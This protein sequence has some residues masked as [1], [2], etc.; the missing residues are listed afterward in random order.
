MTENQIS[1]APRP[2]LGQ[3]VPQRKKP[4]VLFRIVQWAVVAF[5]ALAAIIMAS[6]IG[7]LSVPGAPVALFWVALAVVIGIALIHSPPGVLQAST[8]WQDPRLR[9][10]PGRSKR[11]RQFCRTDE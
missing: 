1:N 3:Q 6:D 5:F 11:V 9:R 8:H 2:P 4:F 7:K 10:H